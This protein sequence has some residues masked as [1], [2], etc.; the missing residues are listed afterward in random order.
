ML[1]SKR[2]L[3][4]AAVMLGLLLT[5]PS[6]AAV[7]RIQTE[8]GIRNVQYDTYN[9]YRIEVV[10]G[11]EIGSDKW[12]IHIYVGRPDSAMQKIVGEWCADSQAEAFD[13]GFAVGQ[14]E[15]DQGNV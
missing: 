7:A 5:N 15:I 1:S 9:G 2:P 4:C 3:N 8:T 11:Y 13:H 10:T 6:G 12:P 14:S